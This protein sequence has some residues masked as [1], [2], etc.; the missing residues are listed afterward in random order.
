MN[1]KLI[2]TTKMNLMSVLK[3]MDEIDKKVL[4]ICDGNKFIGL[5]SIGDIQRAILNNVNLQD[6]ALNHIRKDIT[7]VMDN[8]DFESVKRQMQLNKIECMPVLNSKKELVDIIE[9][10]D[11]FPSHQLPSI[12]CSVV[13]MAGG[14]GK[15]LRPLTN[16]IPKPLIPISDKTIIEEIMDG[17]VKYN[18]HDFHLSVN[19][20]ADTIKEY[21]ARVN[22]PDYSINYI[23]EKEPLGTAGSLY[24]LK[25]DLK[26]TFFVTNCDVLIDVNLSD[27]INFHKSNNNIATLVSIIK[28]TEIPYGTVET[29]GD[30]TLMDLIEKP[31]RSYQINS[32]LYVL[33]PE[34]FNY[35]NDNEFLHITNLLL[36]LKENNKKVG[37]FP[38][39]EKSYTDMGTWDL[40]MKAINKN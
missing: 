1:N 17:F 38:L 3:Y 16:V 36:R 6:L 28:T 7:Y 26:E 39:S 4:F 5:I 32:G 10:E 19:Y 13:I 20:M 12:N 14:E 23:K 29:H 33:E 22:N 15:R 34:V 30:G 37:V 40:Y 24:L 2:I 27:L 11:L 25:N 18:C 31:I 8:Y 35:I 21:F 9:W